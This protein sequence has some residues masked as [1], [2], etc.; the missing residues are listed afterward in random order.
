MRGNQNVEADEFLQY[1]DDPVIIARWFH[2]SVCVELVERL[3]DARLIRDREHAHPSPKDAKC[4]DA[5]ERLRARRNLHHRQ[6][7]TLCRSHSPHVER[8]VSDLRFHDARSEEHT[9]ELPSL[10]RIP[11]AVFCL[12]QKT[13]GYITRC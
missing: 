13:N 8:Q 7:T 3:G 6:R 11:Y 10:M 5:V 4:V 2:A 1:I 12:K 9:S